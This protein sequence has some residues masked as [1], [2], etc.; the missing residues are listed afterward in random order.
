MKWQ[1]CAIA[2]IAK[3]R[4]APSRLTGIPSHPAMWLCAI[5]RN[6]QCR[7]LSRERETTETLQVGFCECESGGTKLVIGQRLHSQQQPEKGAGTYHPCNRST[8]IGQR[9][10]MNN[11]I[12]LKAWKMEQAERDGV[13]V[14]AITMRKSRGKY[15][16]IKFL[17][18]GTRTIF[19][20]T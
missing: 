16:A 17:K 1:S 3:L 6:K 5:R 15:R 18:F 20:E 11:K 12:Q 13:T 8:A 14:S 2:R 19:V 10:D 4:N 7:R 9:N